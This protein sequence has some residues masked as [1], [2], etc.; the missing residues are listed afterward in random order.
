ML[1]LLNNRGR[2][3]L[4]C[5]FADDEAQFQSVKIAEQVAKYLRDT[6]KRLCTAAAAYLIRCQGELGSKLLRDF[7]QTDAVNKELVDSFVRLL[8]IL[9]FSIGGNG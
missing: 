3:L 6:D 4:L 2:R 7:Q 9:D 5:T 1:G 8:V